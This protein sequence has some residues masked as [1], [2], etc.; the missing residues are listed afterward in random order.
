L[1]GQVWI[2]NDTQAISEIHAYNNICV[3]P[4]NQEDLSIHPRA[5]FV[6]RPLK[7]S[8]DLFT[9][10]VSGDLNP[11]P[12]DQSED[13]I[14]E[15]HRADQNN[16]HR[17]DKAQIGLDKVQNF[18]IATDAQSTAAGRGPSSSSNTVYV[19][20]R[21]MALAMDE[22]K[23]NNPYPTVF[24]IATAEQADAAGIDDSASNA[25]YMTPRS[26]YWA[27]HSYVTNN[28]LGGGSSEP[29]YS[30]ATDYQARRAVTSPDDTESDVMMSVKNV[31]VALEEFKLVN[32]I[33]EP[34]EVPEFASESAASVAGDVEGDYELS[35]DTIMSP[36]GVFK[37]LS[38]Y[39]YTY[40]V[41]R[42]TYQFATD[43][44]SVLASYGTDGTLSDVMVSPRG[45]ALTL[46]NVMGVWSA[47]DEV[48]RAAGRGEDN[49]D[50]GQFMTPYSVKIALEEFKTANSI[51]EGDG[52]GTSHQFASDEEAAD[53]GYGPGDA[54]S[55]L[56][57]SPRTTWYAM[58]SYRVLNMAS[59]GDAEIGGEEPGE[60]RDDLFMSPRAV[61]LAIRKYAEQNPS[62]EGGGSGGNGSAGSGAVV[63]LQATLDSYVQFQADITDLNGKFVR[64]RPNPE[65]GRSYSTFRI[66][67]DESA[68]LEDSE[69]KIFNNTP[70]EVTLYL[71]DYSEI[72]YATPSSPYG[73]GVYALAPNGVVTVKLVSQIPWELYTWVVW[74]DTMLSTSD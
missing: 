65:S 15:D 31:A 61:G 74:G 58:D 9:Y 34:G 24:P 16:P 5:L 36:D 30:F 57:M 14:D 43:E 29:G 23:V 53:A 56:M 41:D 38:T 64:L 45:M 2:Y 32:P 44:E 35:T 37:A 63:E 27:I 17:V 12:I 50:G 71:G 42:V 26:T 62:G 46:Q 20:P 19:T 22:Y 18:P 55:D 25:A 52:E 72:L 28:D 54:S 3:Y 39:H 13:T 40:N 49:V 1:G 6:A 8:G 66:W 47:D 68:M 10:L 67:T 69:F 73:D 21:G 70:A 4:L 11:T 7:V 33:P 60:A 59:D 51:G 48:A